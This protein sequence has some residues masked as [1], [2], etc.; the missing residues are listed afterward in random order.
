MKERGILFSAPMVKAL[1][2]GTKTVTRRLFKLAPGFKE[3]YIRFGAHELRAEHECAYGEAGDR[4]WVRE[5]W[6]TL[7]SLDA[8]SP[9]AM[10][11]A[12]LEA[13]W[14]RPWAPI[15]YEADGARHAWDDEAADA[16]KTRVSIHMPRWAS[17]ITLEVTDVRVERLQDISEEDAKAEGVQLIAAAC[18]KNCDCGHAPQPGKAHPLT[19]V[20]TPLEGKVTAANMYR[21]AFADLWEDINGKRAGWASNPFVWRVTF[22][23][24]E[25]KA[26]AA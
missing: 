21:A 2:A 6:R 16:G 26:V 5:T 12:C 8:K 25:P 13:G 20:L 7:K 22:R 3:E 4:L 17:R 24:L 18:D 11:K 19:R 15:Q 14:E 1:L 9:Q 10:A 23:R